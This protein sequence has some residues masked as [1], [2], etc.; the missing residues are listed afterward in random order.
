M[1]NE[2]KKLDKCWIELNSIFNLTR[3]YYKVFDNSCA[4]HLQLLTTRLKNFTDLLCSGLTGNNDHSNYFHRWLT[5][6][7]VEFYVLLIS[8]ECRSKKIVPLVSKFEDILNE[9]KGKL[10]LVLKNILPQ[11]ELENGT[12]ETYSCNLAR[13]LVFT[14][15]LKKIPLIGREAGKCLLRVEEE[16]SCL[17]IGAANGNLYSQYFL[18]CFCIWNIV[19]MATGSQFIGSINSQLSSFRRFFSY[20]VYFNLALVYY[21]NKDILSAERILFMLKD[22]NE[23]EAQLLLDNI[24]KEYPKYTYRYRNEFHENIVKLLQPRADLGCA[25]AQYKL[26]SLYYK[27]WVHENDAEL[28]RLCNLAVSQG[29][30]LAYYILGRLYEKGKGVTQNY[31]K[32]F[33]L[34]NDARIQGDHLS[35]CRVAN[36]VRKEKYGLSPNYAL[37]RSLYASAA[38]EGFVLAQYQLGRMYE[39]GKDLP[40]NYVEAIALY[41]LASTATGEYEYTAD[42]A[43]LRLALMYKDGRGVSQSY[44]KAV[45]KLSF[46]DQNQDYLPAT[47]YLARM[48]EEGQGVKQNYKEAVEL[49]QKIAED[50][51]AYELLARDQYR[52][53]Y[54]NALHRLALMYKDGRGTEQSFEKAVK[55]LW[56]LSQ[57]GYLPAKLSLG[58]MYE[59]GQGVPRSYQQAEFLYRSAMVEDVDNLGFAVPQNR[60]QPAVL[61]LNNLYRYRL[62]RQTP[63]MLDPKNEP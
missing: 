9:A 11:L 61:A 54:F 27:G 19:P 56:R 22:T 46:L 40:P 51:E 62:N 50:E 39:E 31:S 55:L 49:Y 58:K 36:M 44:V 1:I 26:I 12:P 43:K 42:K 45:E 15:M 6:N 16:M 34:F 48:Y 32:A 21:L 57:Y 59:E 30:V 37:S 35:T 4:G 25:I 47:M 28:V 53:M 38:I 63:N 29:H 10:I 20:R 3:N 60:A 24:Y 52:D 14:I 18:L 33:A 7:I 13:K 2:F 17:H 41:N 5:T 23:T 8:F